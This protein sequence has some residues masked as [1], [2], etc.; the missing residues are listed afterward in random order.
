MSFYQI[1]AGDGSVQHYCW[2]ILPKSSRLLIQK[3]KQGNQIWTK[4]PLTTPN[5]NFFCTSKVQYWFPCFPF[6]GVPTWIFH[7]I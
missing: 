6:I 4:F 2:T 1:H 5:S 7:L 3:G